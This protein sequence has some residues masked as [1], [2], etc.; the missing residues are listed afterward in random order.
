MSDSSDNRAQCYDPVVLVKDLADK[1]GIDKL[2]KIAR[3]IRGKGE[4]VDHGDLI[5]QNEEMKF[6]I[7]GLKE[8]IA[9]MQGEINGLR[10]VIRC[11]GVSG[12]EVSLP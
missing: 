1:I 12:S 6:H 2:Y 8:D 7:Q 11:N 4:D 9:M 10:F 5:R 3:D